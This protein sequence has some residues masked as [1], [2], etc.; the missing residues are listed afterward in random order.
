MRDSFSA[1]VR[2]SW[3]ETSTSSPLTSTLALTWNL[4]PG[5]IGMLITASG[6]SHAGMNRMDARNSSLMDARSVPEKVR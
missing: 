3:S 6:K 1:T 5:A 2:R 4:E